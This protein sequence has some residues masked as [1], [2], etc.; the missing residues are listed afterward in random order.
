M[1]GTIKDIRQ[2]EKHNYGKRGKEEMK[3]LLRSFLAFLTAFCLCTGCSA[4]AAQTEPVKTPESTAASETVSVQSQE[5]D[6]FL[7]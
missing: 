5:P 3:H 7:P 6:G 4:P 1:R 2:S